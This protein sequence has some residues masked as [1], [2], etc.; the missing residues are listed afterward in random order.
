VASARTMPLGG[1]VLVDRKRLL[2]LL[3]Q[4]RVAIPANIRQA[5]DIMER[6]EHTLAEA[7]AEA[8]RMVGSARQ[9]AQRLVGE[10]EIVREARAE[11]ARIQREAQTHAQ[12][13]LRDAAAQ[14][15]QE[16][17]QA[18]ES[19]RLQLADADQYALQ[20]LT[21]LDKQISA[22][23]GTVR[24]GIESLEAGEGR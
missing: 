10:S 7:D 20:V 12:T 15:E 2:D 18:R 21:R 23:L 22:F 24:Q 19:A 5:R 4:L 17:A 16:T 3:A 1:G 8:R 13:V 11:A 14:A 9:E 6:R